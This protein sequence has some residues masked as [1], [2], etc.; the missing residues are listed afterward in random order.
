W[1]ADVEC[2]YAPVR[3]LSEAFFDPATAERGMLLRD[4]EGNEHVG[5]PIKFAREP[6][7]PEFRLPEY[8][9]HGGQILAGLGYAEAE[10]ETLARDG[11]I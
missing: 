1:L 6:A 8:G 5:V 11:V 7:Q 9:E 2:A 10:I 3:T 4:A